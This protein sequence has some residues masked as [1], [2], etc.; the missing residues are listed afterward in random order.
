MA[1]SA[2]ARLVCIRMATG[3]FYKQDPGFGFLA[4]FV[5]PVVVE[6][7]WDLTLTMGNQRSHLRIAAEQPLQNLANRLS[8]LVILVITLIFELCGPRYVR[9]GIWVMSVAGHCDTTIRS[10]VDILPCPNGRIATDENTHA[11]DT[12]HQKCVFIFFPCTQQSDLK[13]VCRCR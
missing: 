12:K 6:M 2:W 7:T 10:I 1:S 13:Y 8:C 11:E 4:S 3:G 9:T 5:D